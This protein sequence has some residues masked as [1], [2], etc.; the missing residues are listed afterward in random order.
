MKKKVI[1]LLVAAMML[2]VVACAGSATEKV[3]MNNTQETIMNPSTDVVVIEKIF[4]KLEGIES[5]ECQ[6]PITQV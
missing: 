5:V 2:S 3:E 4:P 6:L 1:S